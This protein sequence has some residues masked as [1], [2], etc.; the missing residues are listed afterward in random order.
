MHS[1]LVDAARE[2]NEEGRD[3]V[4]RVEPGAD[5]GGH[6]VSDG[7]LPVRCLYSRHTTNRGI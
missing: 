7:D 1:A 6:E 4:R 2:N 5:G 3:E